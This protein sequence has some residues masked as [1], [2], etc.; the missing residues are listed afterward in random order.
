MSNKLALHGGTPVV[1][2][3]VTDQWK[4][5]IEEEKKVIGRLLE[6]G[7]ISVSGRGLPKDF[8]D[9]FREYIGCTYVLATSHGHT[10]LASAFF[11][12]GIGA[13]DEF[14]HPTY[15][16]IGSYAGALHMGATPMFCESDPKTLLAD[17]D[18]IEKRITD[19]TKVINPIHRFGRVC[20]M[21]RLLP[22]CEE[23]GIVLIEDAAH[24]HGSTWDGV[25]IGNLGHIAC[26][27]CQGVLPGGKPVA[28][29]EGGIVATNDRELYERA[30]IYCHLHREGALD[31]LTN[32]LYQKLEPQLLGWKWR[33]HPLALAIAQIGLRNLDERIERFS[34][35]REKL[36][37]LIRD[38][39]GIEPVHTY[40][41]SAGAELFGGLQFLVDT[42]R[43]GTDAGRI[44][45]ALKAEGL[46][47]ATNEARHIEHL[48]AIYTQDMPGL[49]GKGHVGPADRPLPRY[50]KGDFPFT[51]SLSDKVFLIKG[52]VEPAEG[53]IE[54]IAEA[55][56]KVARSAG[57]LGTEEAGGKGAPASGAAASGGA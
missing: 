16:Y 28:A 7:E 41:K 6:E 45:E 10:A 22:M 13:G 38:V 39:P 35:N 44:V 54:Q 56:D 3:D 57:E 34:A 14:I 4:R 46:A 50:K 52:W 29:G 42:G 20:D 49:W 15:G 51:E 8:E 40:E 27:S 18:D 33:A 17:P 24:A 1:T 21:D 26:F 30:L 31:E 48:R 55:F 36:Y 37:D 2:S 25:K 5:P 11:A 12:A 47:T 32:P 43:L 9:D 23:R 19:K 53:V